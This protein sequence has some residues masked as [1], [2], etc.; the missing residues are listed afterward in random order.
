M[1]VRTLTPA[2]SELGTQADLSSWTQPVTTLALVTRCS[3]ECPVTILVLYNNEI[4]I[5]SSRFLF[6]FIFVHT[7]ICDDHC[8]PVVVF[9]RPCWSLSE[10]AALLLLLLLVLLVLLLVPVVL[11]SESLHTTD[12]RASQCEP[13]DLAV[14]HTP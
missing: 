10:M 8:Q 13:P 9:L 12:P 2:P 4:I 14:R 1:L 7:F 3:C 11:A 5:Y 6:Y